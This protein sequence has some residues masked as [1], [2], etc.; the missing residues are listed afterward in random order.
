MMSIKILIA[1]DS[2]SDRLII[3]KMLSEYYILI[4]CDGL[5]AMQLIQ[6]HKDIDLLIL[7]LN[8]PKMDGFEVLS[9]LKTD[10]RYKKIRTIILTN[11]DELENEIK[12]L[13]FGAV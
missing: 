5:E 7:D 10:N 13:R 3:R 12:G 9:E 2:A 8:M 4:A 11:Y 1:E 6:E